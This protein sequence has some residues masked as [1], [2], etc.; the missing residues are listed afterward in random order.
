MRRS[1]SEVINDLENRV[2][3]LEGRTASNVLSSAVMSVFTDELS[4]IASDRSLSDV[5]K[6]VQHQLVSRLMREVNSVVKDHQLKVRD[7]GKDLFE[8]A[9]IVSK[10]SS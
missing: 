10:L 1:A 6:Q 7:A 9:N 8:L 3:R 5:E 2:D 4:N